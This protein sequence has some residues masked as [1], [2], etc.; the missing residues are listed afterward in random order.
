MPTRVTSL[1]RRMK[2]CRLRRWKM[3]SLAVVVL[4]SILFLLFHFK[5]LVYLFFFI[6]KHLELNVLWVNLMKL[7]VWLIILPK[8][9]RKK[10]LHF[11]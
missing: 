8:I 7:R 3:G 5:M 10:K 9:K 1:T 11:A 4:N 6:I 2:P